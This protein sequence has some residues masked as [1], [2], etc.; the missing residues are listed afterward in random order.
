MQSTKN[1]PKEVVHTEEAGTDRRL[2]GKWVKGK[3]LGIILPG[4]P[5]LDVLCG[6]TS[7]QAWVQPWG[8]WV[9]QSESRPS[10]NAVL[11]NTEE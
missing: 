6:M 4:C 9:V 7:V 2:G 5:G 1:R 10:F 3:H 8:A 11:A